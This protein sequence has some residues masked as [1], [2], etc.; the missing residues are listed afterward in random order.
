MYGYI[1][2]VTNL[3]NGKIYIGKHKSSKFDKYYYGSGKII[4]RALKKYGKENFSIQVLE[5]GD[6]EEDLIAKERKWIKYF[7]STNSD[8]GYNILEGGENPIYF[9]EQH[10][11]YGKHH[12]EEANN[13]NRLAHIG[14]HHSEE[15]KKKISEGNKGK[16]ISEEH[17]KKISEANKGRVLGDR[18]TDAGRKR[19]SEAMKNR[20]ITE[21]TRK[22]ISD[23]HKGKPLSAEHIKK[24]S[25][26]HKGNPGYWKGKKRS[27]ETLKKISDSLKGR[28]LPSDAESVKKRSDGQKGKHKLTQ[29]QI[30]KLAEAR[31]RSGMYK[32][33]NKSL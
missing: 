3:I 18:L 4:L 32:N 7:D 19:I 28:K 1:Y 9:G 14:K 22:K 26:S 33:R 16:T 24:L 15:T 30:E 11:M 13:K 2:K 27:P 17:K 21:K 5:D 23:A 10:P 12:T 20:V 8:I 29:E 6:S 31:R 25:E